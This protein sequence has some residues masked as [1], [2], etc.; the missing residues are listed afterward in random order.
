L[1]AG[2]AVQVLVDR[3]KGITFPVG[4]GFALSSTLVLTAAF[5]VADGK[6]EVHGG[7]SL[8]PL[9]E[10]T[11]LPCSVV[12][13]ASDPSMPVALLRLSEALVLGPAP[14][15]R[16]V[17]FACLTGHGQIECSVVGF[18]GSGWRDEEPTGSAV[19]VSGTVDPS[20][21]P[22]SKRLV[23]RPTHRLDTPQGFGGA[24]LCAQ[25]A[26][27]G[28][29]AVYSRE[30]G[31]FI[32]ISTRQLLDDTGFREALRAELG[33][34]P[35]PIELTPPEPQVLEALVDVSRADPTNIQ[36]VAASQFALSDLYY[37]NVLAQARRSF[38][39]AVIAALAGSVFFLAAVTFALTTS[40]VA[41]PLV[42][43]LGGSVVEVVAGLNF[44]LYGRTAHQLNSFHLRLERMQRFLVANSVSAGLTGDRRE[45]ALADL[46]KVIAA[47]EPPP[48]PGPPA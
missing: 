42:S 7:I 39:A 5:V 29:V 9:G 46:V 4:S 15:P 2:N 17:E 35:E 13:Q 31:D 26:L 10:G 24:G 48:S 44:W 27:V 41:A 16:A 25:D 32:V 11:E 22:E 28:M 1:T 3:G 30:S 12:W 33:R 21:F 8:R 20:H 47:I 40:H 23:F 43:L 36:E 45:E 19:R 14:G 37:K 34:V 18:P 38:N 6:G